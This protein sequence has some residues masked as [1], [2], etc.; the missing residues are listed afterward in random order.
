MEG[1]S[2]NWTEHKRHLKEEWAFYKRHPELLFLWMAYAFSIAYLIY[3]G[4]A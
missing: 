3:K 4:T 1:G 2:V